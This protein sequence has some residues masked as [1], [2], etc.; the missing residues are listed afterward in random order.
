MNT[1]TLE[2]LTKMMESFPKTKSCPTILTTSHFSKGV[3]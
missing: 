2:E 1:P 3:H